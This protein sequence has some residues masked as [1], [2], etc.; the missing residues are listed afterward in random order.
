MTDVLSLISSL[1]R[2]RL[3]VEAARHGVAHYRRD[4]HLRA[5]LGLPVLPGPRQAS[6]RLLCLEADHD[7]QRRSGAAA[8]SPSSHVSVLIALIAET[9][10]LA[11]EAAQEKASATSSFLR[12]M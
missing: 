12:A 6:M 8:Y 1:E 11:A 9:R 5:M 10:Q 3:L 2:P 7:D 4:R